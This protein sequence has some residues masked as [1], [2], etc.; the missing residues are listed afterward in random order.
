MDDLPFY[1]LFNS[2]SVI[3]GRW[4]DDNERLWAMEPCL[5]LERFPPQAGI[6]PRTARSALNPLRYWGS[7][8][9]R[10][11]HLIAELHKTGSHSCVNP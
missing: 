5:W 7:C 9:R 1:F 6:E 10:K 2:I 11:T 4:L 3:S 8:F